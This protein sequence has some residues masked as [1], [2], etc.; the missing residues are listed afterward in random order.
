VLGDIIYIN[1]YGITKVKQGEP[2]RII[3]AVK[4]LAIYILRFHE[5]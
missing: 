2:L 1:I 4:P 3:D 5:I